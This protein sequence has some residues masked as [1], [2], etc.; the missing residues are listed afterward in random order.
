[1]LFESCL[2]ISRLIRNALLWKW[3]LA[4]FATKL[5]SSLVHTTN[6]KPTKSCCLKCN[7]RW[8]IDNNS[9]PDFVW[10]LLANLESQ[11]KCTSLK[12]KTCIFR[13]ET[14]LVSS[15][16]NEQE[17]DQV[18]LSEAPSLSYRHQCRS[19]FCI[20]HDRKGRICRM[21]IYGCFSS[22]LTSILY[23]AIQELH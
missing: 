21:P 6:K 9:G 10:V 4:S 7:R 17:A 14:L 2:Q 12:V 18:L 23:C 16:Y 11:Q 19:W 22:D 3:R 15:S 1:M 8:D 5:R 20:S 13:N